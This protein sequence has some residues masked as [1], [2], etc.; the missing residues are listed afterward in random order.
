MVYIR[1]FCIECREDKNRD[2]IFLSDKMIGPIK[3]GTPNRFKVSND[4]IQG[5]PR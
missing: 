1:I 2:T 3:K 5:T 4:V